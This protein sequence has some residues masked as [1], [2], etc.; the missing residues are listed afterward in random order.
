MTYERRV[1]L[2]LMKYPWYYP[3]LVEETVMVR[4]KAADKR[5]GPTGRHD[6][7]RGEETKE[8]EVGSEAIEEQSKEDSED[9]TVLESRHV[10]SV[11]SYW[12]P[13]LEVERI[14]DDSVALA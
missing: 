11:V 9:T 14:D 2:T 13:L 10:F 3:Q 8:G 5:T 7:H 6:E 12:S 4:R 1:A